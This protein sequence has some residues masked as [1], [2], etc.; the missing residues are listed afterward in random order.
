MARIHEIDGL[1]TSR[2][3]HRPARRG[4]GGRPAASRRVGWPAY[5]PAETRAHPPGGI[6]DGRP[7][8]CRLRAG[9]ADEARVSRRPWAR[10]RSRC[11][12]TPACWSAATR[13]SQLPWS[14]C[15]CMVLLPALVGFVVAP[16]SP[17]LQ[18]AGGVGRGPRARSLR[19]RAAEVED[20]RGRLH[21]HVAADE[22]QAAAGLPATGPRVLPPRLARAAHAAHRLRLEL[23]EL[24]EPTDLNDDVRR[25]RPLPGRRRAPRG[26]RERAAR[27]R[28]RPQLVAGRRSAC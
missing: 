17:A 19:L 7:C 28:P 14:P 1:T 11:R 5:V 26:H 23:E 9:A 20:P 21:R 13:E 25:S 18:P 24:S 10:R 4:P 2:A 3:P 8:R 22:R 16:C 15:C 6:A 27:V 12:R